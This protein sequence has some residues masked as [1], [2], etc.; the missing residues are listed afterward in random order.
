MYYSNRSLPEERPVGN[1]F[2]DAGSLISM[3]EAGEQGLTTGE[4]MNLFM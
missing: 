2:I 1:A 4:K 3:T